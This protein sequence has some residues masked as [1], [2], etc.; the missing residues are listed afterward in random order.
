MPVDRAFA[1]CSVFS[2]QNIISQARAV[3]ADIAVAHEFFQEHVCPHFRFYLFFHA[4]YL[5][6]VKNFFRTAFAD[7]RA[8]AGSLQFLLVVKVR[9][10][11][12]S[13]ADLEMEVLVD[14]I[15]GWF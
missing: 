13:R 14:C 2:G 6:F 1:S 3:N 10:R 11:T 5:D 9:N 8:Q 4:G 15:E 7:S 12:F